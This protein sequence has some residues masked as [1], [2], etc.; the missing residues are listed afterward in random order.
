MAIPIIDSDT[1][2]T[3]PA[4]LWTSRVASKW[5]E[6]VPH[7]KWDP[8]RRTEAWFMGDENLGPAAASASYGW[9]N[10]CPR[11]RRRWRTRT[12]PPTTPPNA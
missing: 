4:D 3:E 10:Q 9:K 8:E 5:G 6:R 1:H 2:V 12:R 11:C 7:V